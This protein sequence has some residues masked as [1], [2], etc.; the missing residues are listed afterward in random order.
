MPRLRFVGLTLKERVLAASG[1]GAAFFSRQ[2]R[3]ERRP[4][5]LGPL[6]RLHRGAAGIK[7]LLSEDPRALVGEEYGGWALCRRASIAL[8]RS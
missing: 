4:V 5:R 8:S 6:H 1:F 7:K 3:T 2:G